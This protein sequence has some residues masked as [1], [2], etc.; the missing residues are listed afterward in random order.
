MQ[1]IRTTMMGNLTW[2]LNDLQEKIK[3]YDRYY[4]HDN[5]PIHM[6]KINFKKTLDFQ[7]NLK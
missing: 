2:S 7:I 6:N 1:T 3:F 4:Q 5:S